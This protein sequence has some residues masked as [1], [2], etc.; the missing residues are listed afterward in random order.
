MGGAK[1]MKLKAIA[2]LTLIALSALIVTGFAAY[3]GSMSMGRQQSQMG[4]NGNYH[5]GDSHSSMMNWDMD[6]MHRNMGQMMNGPH[7][8]QNLTGHGCH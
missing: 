5:E 8:E 4:M 3:S 1:Q 2:I 7:M 6:E